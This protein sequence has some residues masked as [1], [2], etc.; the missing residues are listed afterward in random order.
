[1]RSQPTI[2]PVLTTLHRVTARRWTSLPEGGTGI[3]SRTQLLQAEH[4][5]VVYNDAILALKDVSFSVEA[6]RVVLLLGANGAGKSTALKAAGGLLAAERGKL[7]RGRILLDG[8]DIADR[9]PFQLVRS[10]LAQVLEGRHCF[11]SLTVEENLRT[12]AHAVGAGWKER[13]RRLELVYTI[14]PRLRDKRQVAAGL[15]SGGEQQMTAIG[16]ALMASPR[17][18]LLDEPSMGLAPSVSDE[19]FSRLQDLNREGVTILLAEQGAEAALEIA[20]DVYVLE[21][22]LVA[23]HASPEDVRRSGALAALYLGE[24]LERAA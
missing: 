5:R 13:K 3:M 14:F 2:T 22:G 23:L 18:L 10:G 7:E 16:R 11:P 4:L 24:E 19:V 9:A 6:G 17:L 20:H 8:L 1:M 12:G 15:T 21:H